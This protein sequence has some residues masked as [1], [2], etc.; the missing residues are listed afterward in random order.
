MSTVTL[1]LRGTAWIHAQVSLTSRQT[2]AGMGP[3]CLEEEALEPGLWVAGTCQ[4]LW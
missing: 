3:G 2:R 1:T 4:G